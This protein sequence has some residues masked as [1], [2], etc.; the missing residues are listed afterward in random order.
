[1]DQ[2]SESKAKDYPTMLVVLCDTGNVL[3]K[4]QKN[5]QNT[6]DVLFKSPKPENT[7]T[8]C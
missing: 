7:I 5:G 4:G 2:Y 3:L 6:W 1:M 8:D